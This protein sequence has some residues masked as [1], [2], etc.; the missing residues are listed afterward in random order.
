[1]YDIWEDKTKY[2]KGVVEKIPRTWTAMVGV[3]DVTV[4][5]HIHYDG[6]VMMSDYLGIHPTSLQSEETEKAQTEALEIL[7]EK[8]IE[9]EKEIVSARYIMDDFLL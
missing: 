1:M 4:T 3:V 7:Y 6:W 2:G 9:K 8:I 5:K